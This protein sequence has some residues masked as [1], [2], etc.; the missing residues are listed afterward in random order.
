MLGDLGL[1]VSRPTRKID[2]GDNMYHASKFYQV[3]IAG[4]ATLY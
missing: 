3:L 4:E 2:P 1:G